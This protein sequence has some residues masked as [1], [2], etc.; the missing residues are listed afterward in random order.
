MVALEHPHVEGNRVEQLV[1]CLRSLDNRGDVVT[2]A[3]GGSASGDN[4][5]NE[6]IWTKKRRLQPIKNPYDRSQQSDQRQ[7]KE[8]ASRAGEWREA[9]EADA[10]SEA[11]GAGEDWEDADVLVVEEGGRSVRGRG[12]LDW[13]WSCRAYVL[14]SDMEVR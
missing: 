3:D 12:R 13:C 8:S 10:S 11:G 5:S 4:G 6:G 2:I 9:A 14:Q 7:P 1:S